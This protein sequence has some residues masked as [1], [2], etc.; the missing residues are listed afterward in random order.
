V[1]EG[2]WLISF[3]G[4]KFYEEYIPMELENW[5]EKQRR[6]EQGTVEQDLFLTVKVITDETFS[7]HQGFDLAIFDEGNRPPSNLPIFHALKQERYNIFKSR[8]AQHFG[9]PGNQIRLWLLVNRQNKTVRLDMYIP[10]DEPS[11]STLCWLMESISDI[12]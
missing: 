3:P 1:A 6:E 10:E 7:R 8:V 4:Q 5:R 12:L 2:F 9:Y 11:L